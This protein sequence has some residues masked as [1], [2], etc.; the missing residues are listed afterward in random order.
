M[1]SEDK[2]VWITGASK[3]IGR[4]LALEFAR[5]GFSVAV[6]ARN[7]YDLQTLCRETEPLKGK[8]LAFALDVTDQQACMT[9][10]SQIAETMGRIDQVILNAGTHIPTPA[11]S[12]NSQ[13]IKTLLDLNVMGV[14][15]C[16]EAVLPYMLVREKGNIA[17]VASLA[18]YRGLTDSAGYGASKAALINLCEALKLDLMGS[19]IKLQVVNP[20]FVETP[21]TDKNNFPMPFLISAETAAKYIVKGIRKNKFEIRFPGTFANLLGILRILPYSFYFPLVSR[22]TANR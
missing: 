13:D 14:V 22:I 4:A 21:L 8:A 16:L 1:L 20:G 6:S 9:I 11:R 2:V 10:F 5:Q 12:F 18:G 15:Y 3:G 19:R 7:E 17:V